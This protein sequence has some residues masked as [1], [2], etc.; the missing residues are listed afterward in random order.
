MGQTNGPPDIELTDVG[1]TS[2][3]T[4]YCRAIE[5]SSDEAILDDPVAVEL[6]RRLD[7]ILRS[8]GVPL[9]RQLSEGRVHKTLRA[10]V[11]MRA[12]HFDACARRFTARHPE[13]YIL[14]LGCG[15][16]TRFQRI[17]DGVVRLYDL[18]RSDVIRAKRGLIAETDRYRFIEASV[19]DTEWMAELPPVG[20][21]ALVLAEGLLMYLALEDVRALVCRLRE[22]CGPAELVAEVFN[23]RWLGPWFGWVVDRK[24]RRALGFGSDA[25]FHSGLASSDEMAEWGEGIDFLGDWS[26]FDDPERGLGAIRFL[27]RIELIRS[28]LRVVHYR[29]RSH[30]PGSNRDD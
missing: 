8:S 5:S 27:G 3:V 10:Y 20:T 19:L 18:D 16:D 7:P 2:L 21:P 14:N 30:P 28:V 6:K 25:R 12:R 1:M 13:G 15:F 23:R 22:R 11:A 24:L 17:D 26:A 9:L 29:L 4:L